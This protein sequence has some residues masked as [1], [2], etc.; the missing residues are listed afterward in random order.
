MGS[1][2]W[3]GVI[4]GLATQGAFAQTSPVAAD[5]WGDDG[6][7]QQQS[8][9]D[10]SGPIAPSP[11][12]DLPNESPTPRPYAGAVWTSGH[13]YW[14]GDSWQ[15][16][17]GGWVER[18]PGYQYINGYWAEDGDVYRWV[19]GGWAPEGSTEVEIPIEVASE[20]VTATRAPPALRVETPPPAPAVGY[21][22]APGYWYWGAN[23][24]E[25][26]S[27]TWMEPPRPGLVFVSPHWVRRG[28]SWVFVGGGWGYNGS[29]RVVV[30]V[31]R[32]AHISVSFG[33]PNVF[34]RSWYRYPGVSWRYYG[35]GHHRYRPNY[36]YA[37]PGPYRYGPRSHDASPGRYNGPS[38]GG[39]RGG[40]S[41]PGPYRPQG[42]G[43]HSSNNGGGNSGGWGGTRSPP[44]GGNGTRGGSGAHQSSGGWG[45][46][47]SNP[48]RPSSGGGGR[49]QSS[50][51]GGGGWVVAAPRAASIRPAADPPA[52]ATA[53]AAVG[54]G[55]AAPA[56]APPMVLP[57]AAAVG[58]A[59]AGVAVATAV[60][61][62]AEVR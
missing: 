25:W 1:R 21:T 36:H 51:G 33:R 49:S 54:A 24:Y 47:S 26:V 13:W 52:A 45:G 57:P 16:K 5:D 22:W 29:V 62:I 18:M 2:W 56:A 40:Y 9:A 10:D 19:S 12:P 27:G 39:G 38:H 42:S 44:P 58:M 37:R 59:A 3:I 53:A 4:V 60:V 14:D 46:G 41:R 32:H 15:F 23:G 20:D 8:N 6:Y 28:L 30:P 31:Y 17:S 61:A 34:L 35:Y 55:A 7:E 50:G 43:A 11:P 48:G